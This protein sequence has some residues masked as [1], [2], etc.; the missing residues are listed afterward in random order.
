MNKERIL[1]IDDD[2]AI[3]DACFQVLTRSGYEAELAGTPEEALEL[4]SKF[5]FDVILLD[6]KMPGMNGLEL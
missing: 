5:E 6:L 4:I 2:A 1:I 3:R